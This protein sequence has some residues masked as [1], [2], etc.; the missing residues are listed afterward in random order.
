M[1]MNKC[2]C[3]KKEIM[4]LAV[5]LRDVVHLPQHVGEKLKQDLGCQVLLNSRY[6]HTSF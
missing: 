2:P 6:M 1:C 5:I 3:S 4:M